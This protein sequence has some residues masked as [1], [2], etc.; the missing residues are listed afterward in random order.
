[1][2]SEGREVLIVGARGFGDAEGAR[3]V[4]EGEA[5]VAGGGLFEEG[6]FALAPF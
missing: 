3:S 5:A 6:A 1:M 2:P 4:V